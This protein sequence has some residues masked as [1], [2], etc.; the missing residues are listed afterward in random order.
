[1]LVFGISKA[2][3][4]EM[5]QGDK[6]QFENTVKSIEDKF[7]VSI[8][9][10][11]E[12]YVVLTNEEV[13]KIMK[14]DNIDTALKLLTSGKG[15][16]YKMLRKDYYVVFQNKPKTGK[17]NNQVKPLQGKDRVIKGKITDE[18]GDESSYLLSGPTVAITGAT[19][20]DVYFVDAP[21]KTKY[22]AIPKTTNTYP[23]NVTG[24]IQYNTKAIK[25]LAEG[26]QDNTDDADVLEDAI[27]ANQ[28]DIEKLLTAL[29]GGLTG[30]TLTKKSDADYDFEWV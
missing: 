30:Q 6:A 28:S 25:D 1:M 29:A 17:T 4:P 2:G 20:G 12:A 21:I 18:N 3:I 7:N 22:S 9:Y 16:K 27:Q 13:S 14:A 10:D 19:E 23:Q 15:L 26:V 5:T 11:A 24:Q 8:T